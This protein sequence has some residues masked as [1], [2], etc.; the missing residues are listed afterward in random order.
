MELGVGCLLCSAARGTCT[1]RL[2]VSWSELSRVKVTHRSWHCAPGIASNCIPRA[3]LVH[4]STQLWCRVALLAWTTPPSLVQNLLSA[5]PVH[6]HI[7]MRV[8][9][10][11]RRTVTAYYINRPRGELKHRIVLQTLHWGETIFNA[12]RFRILLALGSDNNPELN[13]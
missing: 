5:F 8:K 13:L 7:C 11:L 6:A 2:P 3:Y 9:W 10:H 12:F 1:E 4:S